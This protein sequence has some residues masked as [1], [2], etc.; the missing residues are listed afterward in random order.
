MS[1]FGPSFEE[2]IDGAPV[3]KQVERVRDRM[4]AAAILGEWLTVEELCWRLE[5]LWKV[6]FPETSVSSDLRH[7]RKREFGFYDVRRRRREGT[8]ISEYRIFAREPQG[9]LFQ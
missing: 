6:Q 7:L 2:R 5:R 1:T 4:L 3:R 9:S 8:R